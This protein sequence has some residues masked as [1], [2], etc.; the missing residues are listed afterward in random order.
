LSPESNFKAD[1]LF[2]L[3]FFAPALRDLCVEDLTAKHTKE[4]A[5]HAKHPEVN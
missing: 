5:Q 3:A 1:T 4:F 2:D